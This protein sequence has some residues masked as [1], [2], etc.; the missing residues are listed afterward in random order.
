MLLLSLQP[1]GFLENV[2]VMTRNGRR[3]RAHLILD[4]TP[5]R[6]LLL[7]NLVDYAS[8]NAFYN[9]PSN[10]ATVGPGM[11]RQPMFDPGYPAYVN[12]ASVGMLVGHE[13]NHGF[14]SVGGR[15]DAMGKLS[16]AKYFYRSYLSVNS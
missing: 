7:N 13:I 3:N 4:Q 15:F 12:Y 1:K 9:L 6:D 10:R 14:D 2:M 5:V 8:V 11:A 16:L